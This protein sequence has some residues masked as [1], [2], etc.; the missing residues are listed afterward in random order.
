GTTITANTCKNG[1]TPVQLLPGGSCTVTYDRV[2]LVSDS[3]PII[4]TATVHMHPNG[5]PNDLSDD[6]Q[7]SIN[8]FQPSVLVTK[9]CDPLSKIT[10]PLSCTVTVKNTGSAD[11]P[12]LVFDQDST[13]G[14]IDS[15]VGDLLGANGGL[16]RGTK[17]NTSTCFRATSLAVNATCKVD[18][19]FTVLESD[20]DP[21]VNVVSTLM[22][23]VGFPNNITDDDTASTNLFQPAIAVA[24]SCDDLSKIGDDAYCTDTGSNSGSADSANL[25]LDSVSDTVVGN[26]NGTLSRGSKTSCPTFPPGGLA[27]GATWTCT[28]KFAVV[29]G[30]PDPIVNTVTVHTHP[31]GFPNDIWGTDSETI[32][33]FQPSVRV[34]KTCDALSKATDPAY[35]TVTVTNNGSADSPALGF[36]QDPAKGLTDTVVGDLLVANG[37]LTRG[38]KLGT[39]TCF[40]AT[41]LAVNASCKVDSLFT[42]LVSDSDPIVNTA[43]AWM[44]PAGFPNDIRDDDVATINL[45]QPSVATAIEC[46]DLSKVGDD[47]NC[48][49]T[50]SNT[51]SVDSPNLILDS[52]N[53]TPVGNLNG[54]LTRGTK[55]LCP[56]FPVG[57]LPP[58]AT[59]TC[60]YKFTVLETDSD[61][62]SMSVVGLF[63]PAGFPN[64]ITDNDSETVDLFQ[65][66][67]TV[68]KSANTATATLGQTIR[69][70][71]TVTNTG[72]ADSPN[73]VFDQD[74]TK[75]LVDSRAGDLLR[76]LNAG[77]TLVSRT[78]V[79]ATSLAVNTSCN[80]VYD[81]VI[82]AGDPDP[83]ENVAST[84]MHPVG[85][86]NDIT[87]D[88]DATVNLLQ[89]GISIKKDCDP[90]SKETD[91]VNCTV[92][93]KNESS[94]D[95]GNVGFDQNPTKG[96]VD[97]INPTKAVAVTNDLLVP[98]G[99]MNR[100]TKLGTST[101]FR[102]TTLAPGASCKVD[103]EFIVLAS[104]PDPIENEAKTLL[105]PTLPLFAGTNLSAAVKATIN[106]FQ[107]SL[108]VEKT[109][110]VT[111]PVNSGGLA[112]GKT[113]VGD[114]LTY[115]VTVTN[116]GSADSPNLTF[117]ADPAKGLVDDK[118]G[119]LLR[120][121]NAGY[122]LVSRTCVPAT[123]LAV[124][125]SC[126]VVFT[127]QVT[128]GDPDP[129][130]NRASAWMHPVGFPNDIKGYKDA[131]ID[132]VHPDFSITKQCTSGPV[133]L[134]ATAIFD[135]TITNTG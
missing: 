116:N 32:N 6:D 114:T 131:S 35:C 73:L 62:I 133:Q 15:V 48:S 38:T 30:D 64:V 103:Y 21:L 110:V 23:P 22:H 4:N 117:D 126:T 13:K 109:V 27:P 71:V 11:S 130:T 14:L 129:L 43:S 37:P 120:T 104:D 134:G 80:V 108:S 84:L 69:Y 8:L 106:L 51:S 111:T 31:A 68:T 118:A 2:T 44:H 17:L 39:S 16:T 53:A 49:V 33:L 46:D 29:V 52:I 75:G 92:T 119:D 101:C 9:T 78:C 10:D 57:G 76:T 36:D 67:V 122:T 86:P 5:F 26:L 113:V 89:F 128:G 88:G 42:V 20:P 135:I 3:D 87:D 115:T 98:V 63:H 100:G 132:I 34:D 7:A 105:H 55:V 19:V 81:H 121:L 102:A 124:G 82:V 93:V 95:S 24:K 61:P 45:F 99:A 1:G 28:Y 65:P 97:T 50:V 96:L 94:A 56:T 85:F 90:L 112:A 60:T 66:D 107:P 79:P 40:R 125:A 58:G 54:T 91:P 74:P 25:I 83:L 77:Y 70:T 59:W 18:Y 47:V 41:T 72:S 123:S 127:H 12:N